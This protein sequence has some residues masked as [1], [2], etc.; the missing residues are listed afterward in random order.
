[1]GEWQAELYAGD[2]DGFVARRNSLAKQA[3]ADGEPELAKQI[4]SCRKPA[5][6]AWLVNLLAVGEPEQL[7]EALDL[8]EAL[9]TAHR[10]A[11]GAQLREL[12]AVRTKT[13]NALARRAAELGAE[14]GYQAPSSAVAEVAETIQAALADPE[15]ARGIR[16]GTMTATVRAAGFGPVDLF[17]PVSAGAPNVIDLASRRKARAD[18]S[19]PG[20]E[21]ASGPDPAVIRAAERALTRAEMALEQVAPTHRRLESEQAAARRASRAATADWESAQRDVDRLRAELDEAEATLADK[22]EKATA[23]NART[24]VA[25]EAVAESQRSITALEEA[26][27]QARQELRDM[28]IE[29]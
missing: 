22:L 11:S 1:M 10:E 8:G 17:A 2:F 5:R 25:D 28:G 6:A 18:R 7:G 15:L 9:A 3:K 13:V 19:R 27:E 12:S 16:T 14:H 23:A 4:Q 29:P 21:G 26:M 24:E 20:G